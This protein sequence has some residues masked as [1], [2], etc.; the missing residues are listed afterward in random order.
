M[1]KT[2]LLFSTLLCLCTFT[3]SAQK[4][5]YL[6][7]DPSC[8]DRLEY[9]INGEDAKGVEYISY[10]FA[11]N[12][13]NTYFFEVGTENTNHSLALPM[14][15]KNC[16][17]LTIDNSFVN[18]VRDGKINLSIVRKDDIGYNISPV[19]LVSQINT[20]GENIDLAAFDFQAKL[21]TGEDNFRKNIAPED[22]PYEVYYSGF[23]TVNGLTQHYFRKQSKEVCQPN[24]DYTYVQG[25]GIINEVT[26]VS[27]LNPT[28]STMHLVR[29]NEVSMETYA[30]NLVNKSKT[31]P[32]SD[33][34]AI[35]D[36][37]IAASQAAEVVEPET[38]AAVEPTVIP[39]QYAET[40]KKTKVITTKPKTAVIAKVTEK[41]TEVEVVTTPTP[42]A[43]ITCGEVANENEH[44]VQQGETQFG[45]ARKYS[46]TVGQ[47]R[48][49][50][51]LGENLA[52]CQRLKTTAPKAAQITKVEEK[53]SAKAPVDVLVSKGGNITNAWKSNNTGHHTVVKGETVSGLA[54]KYG[55]SEER[56]LLM[57][58]LKE[59]DVIKIGQDLK[60]SD[61]VCDANAKKGISKTIEN[62]PKE[63][64]APISATKETLIEK[65]M[66]TMATRQK[67]VVKLE[68]AA[69]MA[70]ET[71]SSSTFMHKT[72]HVV[73]NDET[74]QTIAKKHNITV[75]KLRAINSLE[76]NEVLIPT[77]VIYVD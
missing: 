54:H 56:F 75:A 30:D 45:I 40:S 63:Y 39:A 21:N 8:M 38:V 67:E 23:D 33:S 77:Q 20:N 76:Q 9:H 50:N 27:S 65:G 51:E 46:I 41:V 6:Q 15:I 11:P 73:Q 34:F 55:F 36:S 68:I 66:P 42:K 14:G 26:H 1:A 57:N 12:Q 37:D 32:L 10:R 62:A 3:L 25:L 4:D 64:A 31:A 13:Q 70:S 49:W 52:T 58:D 19:H 48:A 43:S 17:T 71:K 44:I 69:P 35:S 24:V 60:I 72:I 29:V 18:K 22:N 28:E 74:V 2:S 16:K 47:L 53:I 59:G 61:C 7:L 5:V